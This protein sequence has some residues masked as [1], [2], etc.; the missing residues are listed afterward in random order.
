MSI[1]EVPV[2]KQRPA[3]PDLDKIQARA[4]RATIAASR[5]KPDGT[6]GRNI[7]NR[8]VLF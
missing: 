1:N 5:E 2:I 7:R 6:Q 4:P 3:L 8:T